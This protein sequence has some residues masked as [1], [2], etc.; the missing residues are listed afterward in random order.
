MPHFSSPNVLHCFPLNGNPNDP[1]VFAIEGIMGV[2]M[3]VLRN[4]ELSG[5][6]LFNPLITEAMKV[7]QVHKSQ[8]SNNYNILLILTGKK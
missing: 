3:N 6:T 4:V 7:A 2:Y 1:E 8:G 5:P